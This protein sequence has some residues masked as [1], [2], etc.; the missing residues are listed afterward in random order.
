M[1]CPTWYILYV[2]HEECIVG[3]EMDMMSKMGFWSVRIL[4]VSEGKVIVGED[5][6]TE[7][8]VGT[9]ISIDDV[10]SSNN[11]TVLITPEEEWQEEGA[12]PRQQ[13]IRSV[14]SSFAQEMWKANWQKGDE[15]HACPSYVQ[16]YT[17]K[18]LH[19]QDVTHKD[20]YGGTF[21][22]EGGG[23]GEEHIGE[24]DWRMI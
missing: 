24:Y 12:C 20:I 9:S 19:G 22:D 15:R 5:R 6:M 21:I 16:E 13:C 10:V 17:V 1:R 8:F 3:S 7:T 4:Q 14:L 2:Y 18:R 11:D 23:I